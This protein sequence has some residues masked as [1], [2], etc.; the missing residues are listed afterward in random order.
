MNIF[1]AQSVVESL[2]NLH[3]T[4]VI[5][6]FIEQFSFNVV[7]FNVNYI[8]QYLNY[9]ERM[10]FINIFNSLVGIYKEIND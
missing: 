8:L 4:S 3:K 7:K 2:Y 1:N 9:A 5:L 10:H 6:L